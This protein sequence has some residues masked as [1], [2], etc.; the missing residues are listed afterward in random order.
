M[1]E[2]RRSQGKWSRKSQGVGEREVEAA[3]KIRGAAHRAAR[4][5]GDSRE[6]R[7]GASDAVVRSGRVFSL[8]MRREASASGVGMA[9]CEC[10][11]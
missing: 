10:D 5:D 4:G 2:Q 7:G 11:A 8:C 9:E 6:E 3:A 1:R